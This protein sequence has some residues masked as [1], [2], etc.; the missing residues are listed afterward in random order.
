MNP[1]FNKNFTQTETWKLQSHLEKNSLKTPMFPPRENKSTKL[2]ENSKLIQVEND[3]IRTRPQVEF[4][5]LCFH[6]V[7]SSQY[8]NGFSNNTVPSL[9][10][11][12]A[13][14][15]YSFGSSVKI[16]EQGK[17][18]WRPATT[19][20]IVTLSQ[21][22]RVVYRRR[23]RNRKTD[24]RTYRWWWYDASIRATLDSFMTVSDFIGG[25]LPPLLLSERCAN[26]WNW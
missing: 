3:T 5:S 7:C 16:D 6:K 8:Q 19:D 18:P 4:Y 14:Q 13:E 24:Q 9:V 17:Y 1:R 21:N 20:S 12:I 22:H 25:C 23:S 10:S 26:G 15:P 11:F 2:S